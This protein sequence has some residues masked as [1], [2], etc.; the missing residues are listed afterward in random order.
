[1]TVQYV[2][3]SFKLRR[4][5]AGNL[6]PVS[7]WRIS[8]SEGLVISKGRKWI[9]AIRNLFIH[10]A[11]LPRSGKTNKIY[12][13]PILTHGTNLWRGYVWL[14]KNSYHF[15]NHVSGTCQ[16]HPIFNIFRA[17]FI[18]REFTEKAENR[19]SGPT[20]LKEYLET[21]PDIAGPK[22]RRSHPELTGWLSWPFLRCFP[23]TQSMRD[24][25]KVSSYPQTTLVNLP[26]TSNDIWKT[27]DLKPTAM[28]RP[29]SWSKKWKTLW[30]GDFYFTRKTTH[31]DNEEINTNHAE[32]A[33]L[34]WAGVGYLQIG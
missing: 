13:F 16:N 1:M 27:L 25:L 24:Y 2:T 11:S 34:Q 17:H 22:G 4:H 3:R 14:N 32:L 7:L 12:L 23:W 33:S 30:L 8:R 5:T 6:K 31:I 9:I 29:S 19:L 26:M 28:I 20:C 21:A 18:P 10:C 15:L